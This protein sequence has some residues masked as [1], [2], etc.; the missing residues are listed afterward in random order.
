MHY[1]SKGK[2][3]SYSF[4]GGWPWLREQVITEMSLKLIWVFQLRRKVPNKMLTI[5][6]QILHS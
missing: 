5:S 6:L 1:G 4:L 3:N 2:G